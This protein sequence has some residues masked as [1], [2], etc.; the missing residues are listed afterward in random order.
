MKT[1][2]FFLPLYISLNLLV[3]FAGC[4]PPDELQPILSPTKETA[5]PIISATVIE[6]TP[7]ATN[8]PTSV[9]SSTYT[10]TPTPSITPT[11]TPTKI[12]PTW[13]PLATL[14]TQDAETLI[15]HLFETNGDCQLPCWWGLTPGLTPWQSAQQ[16]LAQFATIETPSLNE[17][18]ED[19]PSI[20]TTFYANVIVPVPVEISDIY[21]RQDFEV[22]EGFIQSITIPTTGNVQNYRL[23][24]FLVENGRPNEILIRTYKDNVQGFLPF[25]IALFYSDKGILAVYYDQFAKVTGDN[26]QGCFYNSNPFLGLWD[27]TNE[28]NFVSATRK[29]NW[30]DSYW[31][32]LPLEESTDISQDQFYD[33]YIERQSSACLETPA[34]LWPEP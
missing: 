9:P 33:L 30:F 7:T 13:T 4:S 24:K 29:F 14:S 25:E 1:Y 27:P 31:Q 23:S 15:Y 6:S 32:F 28:M 10:L 17:G 16:L 18:N 5:S 19:N 12:P 26:V 21:F 34:N 3:L 8:T 11:N 2:K 22:Q 20:K